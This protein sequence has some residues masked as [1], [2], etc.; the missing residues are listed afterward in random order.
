[1]EI[2]GDDPYS[3]G[4]NAPRWI[5][6]APRLAVTDTGPGI[7]PKTSP[8]VFDGLWR[9]NNASSTAAIAAELIRAHQGRIE[10]ASQP[11]R[12]ATFTA[13]LTSGQAA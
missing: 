3:P 4:W 1:M 11:G 8:R 7:A 2:D 13:I 10:L 6:A 5:A 9:G 12:G